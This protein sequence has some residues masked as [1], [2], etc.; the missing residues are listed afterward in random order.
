MKEIIFTIIVVT[1]AMMLFGLALFSAAV[2]IQ[3]KGCTSRWPDRQT[4]Y[5][6]FGG[7]LVM[8]GGKWWP[9]NNVRQVSQ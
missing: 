6:V 3:G 5:R 4:E 2:F 9:E 1:V 8:D 7:C